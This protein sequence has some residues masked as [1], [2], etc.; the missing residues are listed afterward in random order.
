MVI[1]ESDLTALKK[2]IEDGKQKYTQAQGA[3]TELERTIK[4]YDEELRTA[5][6][7]PDKVSEWL[8]AEESSIN[9]QYNKIVLMIPK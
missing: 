8:A 6:V 5:G 4:G 9:E 7:D 1:S 3:L 2:K